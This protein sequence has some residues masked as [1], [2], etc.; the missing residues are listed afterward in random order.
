MRILLASIAIGFSST[1]ALAQTTTEMPI[2]VK[3]R[4]DQYVEVELTTDVDALTSKQR[5]MIGLLIDAAKIMD[6]CFWYEAYGD[7]SKLLAGISDPTDHRFTVINYGP[8]DRLAGNEPFIDGVGAKPLGANFYPVD[9]TKDEFEKADL[10][11]KDGLYNFIRRDENGSLK[12]VPYRDQFKPEM[13]RASQLLTDAAGLADDAGLRHYLLLRADALLTDDYRPSDMAWLEMH[14][15]TIDTVI[16]PIENYEDQLYGYKTAHEAYVLVKDKDWSERLAKYAT[17]LPELQKTL[18]VADAYKQEE[19]GT[20]TELNA[21]D[22][23]YYAGD[24]NSGSKTIAINLPNDETVQLEKGT[25]RLQLKNAMR[26]KFDKILLPIADV[27][28]ADDQRKHITFD[29]FFSNTMFHEVAHGLGIKNTINDRGPVRTA[30]KEHAGAIEEGKADILGLHMINQ[31]HQKG[32]IKED[33][34][35]FYVTFMAGIFRSVRFGASSAHGKANMIRFNFFR[36]AN[37][38]ERQDDGKYRVNVDKFRDA[39][40]DLSSL[41]LKLQ[42]D[43][44]YD[45]VT[46][47]IATKGVIGEQLQ[48]ELDLLSEKGIPVD[49]VF[50]Q[51]KD[52][53]GITDNQK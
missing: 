41:L 26:A 19:P 47:L 36:D 51:G 2:N 50:R 28:I 17:F 1:A 43:G 4:V 25:R 39:T 7:K 53:L 29:A 45:A 15:N 49:V 23:I 24:C 16:G 30:L 31:L 42:G 32:E 3:Q 12:S 44:D 20:D 40:R 46:D 38:F 5:Q 13:A 9:M 22:V 37:A 21:Y 52:V 14:D 48:S 35:D 8:W 10:S 27:L 34:T 18:P 11:G 33:L 6:D